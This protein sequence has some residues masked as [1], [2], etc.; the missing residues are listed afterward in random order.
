[1]TADSVIAYLSARSVRSHRMLALELVLSRMMTV[2]CGCECKPDNMYGQ[3]QV[4][5]R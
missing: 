5:S 1:M 3:L 2:I 4:P